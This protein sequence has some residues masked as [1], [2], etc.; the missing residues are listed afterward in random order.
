MG[1]LQEPFVRLLQIPFETWSSL[2]SAAVNLFLFFPKLLKVCMGNVGN[3][4]IKFGKGV[5][6]W[7]K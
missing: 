2:S 5:A 4:T 7:E 6:F 3:D 1:D